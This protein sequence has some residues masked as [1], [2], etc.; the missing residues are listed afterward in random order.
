MI[1][2]IAASAAMGVL[3]SRVMWAAESEKSPVLGPRTVKGL[4][5]ERST[6]VGH[7]FYFAALEESA[8]KNL[9][10]LAL[11]MIDGNRDGR[12][13]LFPHENH[14]RELGGEGSCATCHHQS[15]PFDQNTSCHECHRD[16]YET[17]D[18]F[19]HAFHIEKLHG[20][21]GCVRCHPN[22]SAVKTRQTSTG[23]VECHTE[24]FVA[25]SRVKTPAGGT[26]GFAPG[27]MNVFH[28]LCIECHRERSAEKPQSFGDAFDRC[29]GCHGIMDG[30]N[31]LA[32]GPY[33]Q[34]SS[35]STARE[36]SNA[37]QG[38]Q[39]LGSYRGL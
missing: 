14:K 25:D 39:K 29:D 31:L 37:I 38:Y 10:P 21:P 3:A 28:E 9:Q 16:M 34:P 6:G 1:A 26:T 24:M 18:I 13:V 19:E 11:L 4:S 20:D 35:L 7:E 5:A 32:F 30:S 15:M 22:D 8:S 23:C 27:Y 2:V 17:T 33:A 36:G 12:F